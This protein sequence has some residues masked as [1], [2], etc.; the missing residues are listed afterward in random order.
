VRLPCGE[1][2]IKPINKK[3]IMSEILS[4]TE[5]VPQ[6]VTLPDG[7]YIGTWSGCEIEIDIHYNS[8]QYT[9]KTKKGVRGIGIKVVVKIV[10]GIATF[11]TVKN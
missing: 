2:V 3:D 5:K 11:E 7:I 9:L 10:Q 8:K 6:E 4:I 1:V